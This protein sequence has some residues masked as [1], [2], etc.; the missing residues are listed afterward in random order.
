MGRTAALKGL[1]NLFDTSGKT[2]TEEMLAAGRQ[3]SADPV[4]AKQQSDEIL[5][6]ATDETLPPVE[7]GRTPERNINI[8]Y[9]D[10]EDGVNQIVD[11]VSRQSDNAGYQPMNLDELRGELDIDDDELYS[12]LLGKKSLKRDYA[13]TGPQLNRAREVV[14]TSATRLRDKIV[15]FSE[16]LKIDDIDDLERLDLQREM[17]LHSGLQNAVQKETRAAARSLVMHKNVATPFNTLQMDAMMNAHGG[18]EV[19]D[20]KIRVIADSI[21]PNASALDQL[22]QMNKAMADVADVKWYNQLV[23]YRNVQ[24]LSS[25]VTHA[26]NIIG[27]TLTALT[28]P[29]ERLAAAGIS[30]VRGGDTEFGE[31][32]HLLAGT[33]GSF[34][35]GLRMARKMWQSGE[36]Q[37][38]ATKFDD[39]RAEPTPSD[40]SK[41]TDSPVAKSWDYMYNKLLWPGKALL[42]EDEFFKTLAFNGEM[43][44]AA[45]RQARSEGLR[46]TALRSRIDELM[47]APNQQK[48]LDKV[49]DDFAVRGDDGDYIPEFQSK[50][51]NE[52]KVFYDLYA[53]STQF[54][55]YQTYTDAL[56]TDFAKNLG[57]TLRNPIARLIVPFYR[58]PA[59]ILAYAVERSPAAPLT[60]Q[61]RDDFAAGGA[62]RDLA[63]ARIAMGSITSV[64]IGTAVWNG[65]ITGSGPSNP[66]MRDTYKADGWRPSSIKIDDKWVTY[67]GFDP[68]STQ[69][70]VIANALDM[71]RYATTDKQREHISM[72]TI[73]AAAEAV[74]DRSFMQGI[75]ELSEAFERG[76]SGGAGRYLSRTL[77]SF[78]PQSGLLR[79]T[80]KTFTDD[81]ARSTMG[82]SLMESALNEIKSMVPFYSESLPPQINVWGEDRRYD[83]P[84][85][86]DFLS[87]F[88]YTTTGDYTS[89]TELSRNATPIPQVR[90]M[91]SDLNGNQI[92][93]MKMHDER[94][95]GW[96]YYELQ[97]RIGE[98]RKKVVDK[99]VATDSYKK[100][101]LGPPDLEDVVFTQ[102]DRLKQALQDGRQRGVAMFVKANKDQIITMIQEGVVERAFWPTEPLATS[103]KLK[104]ADKAPKATF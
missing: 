27:N 51:G 12:R 94:G 6:A 15:D 33:L 58:T 42:A 11:V 35:D 64:F 99:V 79:N 88:G 10:T 8:D 24:L 73:F 70:A 4:L 18:R 56:K 30:K 43:R 78:L 95:D 39:A 104:P 55:H 80:R 75:A 98:E 90:S 96:A 60:R 69:M 2:Q 86:P 16:R 38:G 53:K 25:P 52:E 22:G 68:F 9:L 93:S 66:S 57:K 85:G 67:Q 71:Y 47:S 28:A 13:L 101:P 49:R 31:A 103:E 87:P 59:N 45:F 62:R 74:K 89:A 82:N 34:A 102:G 7:G 91:F 29:L 44:A 72:V 20:G 19:I 17:L 81:I 5:T 40:V 61:W 100:L 65:M 83:E 84:Y 3:P 41:Y 37:F 36:S 97:K 46:S 48:I 50:L 63:E 76:K 21:D 1:K 54:A 23:G 26:R 32:Y 14:A 77:A 92:D